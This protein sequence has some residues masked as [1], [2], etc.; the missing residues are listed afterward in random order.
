MRRL[1]FARL[2]GLYGG[3]WL[4]ELC[5]SPVCANNGADRA[6]GHTTSD[7]DELAFAM[8]ATG[9]VCH[10]YP[11]YRRGGQ[12]HSACRRTFRSASDAGIARINLPTTWKTFPGTFVAATSIPSLRTYAS[13]MK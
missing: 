9:R 2:Y 10:Q 4:P 5:R 1:A 3:V 8:S 11:L 7:F 13:A 6:S 12:S